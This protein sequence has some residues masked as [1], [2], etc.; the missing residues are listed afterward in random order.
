MMANCISN[1]KSEEKL[2]LQLSNGG[3][4]VFIS[5][6]ALAGS[7]L[8]RIDPEIEL[9]TWLASQDQSILGIGVVG[10]DLMELP[11]SSSKEIFKEQHTFLR[12]VIA[13][14]KTKE[15]LQLLNYDPS[16]QSTWTLL[17]KCLMILYI[18]EKSQWILKPDVF[19]EKC[20]KHGVFKHLEGC[21]ICNDK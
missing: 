7:R 2:F 17:K 3:T 21:I 16:C 9:I 12:R 8:A 18:L 4:S 14:A 11:W 10:F 20:E 1:D 19:G 6:L 5:V 15:T 13:Q